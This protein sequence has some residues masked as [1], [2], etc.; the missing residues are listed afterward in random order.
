[1]LQKGSPRAILGAKIGYLGT[2]EAPERLQKAP[3]VF[4]L[5]DLFFVFFFFEGEGRRKIVQKMFFLSVFC[6]FLFLQ[7]G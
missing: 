5:Y 4:F 2:Q 1:M 3:N 7:V 6:G